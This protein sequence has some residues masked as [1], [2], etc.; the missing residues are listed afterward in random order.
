M[1]DQTMVNSGGA[2]PNAGSA[3][4]DQTGGA[5]GADEAG[6]GAEISTQQMVDSLAK[7]LGAEAEG[8]DE[9]Q[10]FRVRQEARNM[11]TDAQSS[12]SDILPDATRSQVNQMVDGMMN[13]DVGKLVNAIRDAL[14]V[15]DEKQSNSRR[16]SAG[17][18]N[19]Q[20]TGNG[21]GGEQTAPKNMTEAVLNASRLFTA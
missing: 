13:Q 8:M 10:E 11:I 17:K 19:V 3:A 2:D 5:A 16:A 6:G 20:G 1:Q 4:G 7:T 18:I 14:K 12:F 9:N 15:T 21:K